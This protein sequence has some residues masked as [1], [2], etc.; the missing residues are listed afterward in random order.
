MQD[1]ARIAEKVAASGRVE[2]AD[3][4][5]VR[6]NVYSGDATISQAEAEALFAIERR[7]RIHN[8]DW[9]ALFVEAMTDHLLHQ[10]AP[11]GYLSADNAAWVTRQIMACKSPSADVQV[12]LVSRLIEE[13]RE[14]PASFSAFALQLVKETVIHSDGTDAAG[15]P[16]GIGRVTDAD[17]ALLSR[18]LWG[19]GG[20]GQL[21]VSR[22]EAEALF[23]ISDAT[24]G[25]DN[26]EAFND[27]FAR[28]IGNYLLGAT[29]RA[30]PSREDALR[31]ETDSTYKIDTLAALSRVV[32]ASP[33]ALSPNFLADTLRNVRSLGEDV[34]HRQEAENRARAVANEVA[35]IMSP[36]KA[37]WLLDHIDRNGVMTP[38]E[39]ALVR[40]VA[41]ESAALD[42]SLRR[43]MEKVE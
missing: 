23:A 25:A 35:S 22:E 15:R 11:A 43:A 9:S 4:L 19:A 13:A 8:P 42:A 38:S 29:G 28:A 24:T 41:R 33:R 12:E 36:E 30:V 32:A 39:K 10:V 21:A 6:R 18:I 20:E 5:E 1:L 7:R 17:L 14:V 34:D 37:G 16:L 27:F 40:F 31:W 26:C 3:L 2:S